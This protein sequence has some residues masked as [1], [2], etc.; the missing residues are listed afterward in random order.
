MSSATQDGSNGFVR[1]GRVNKTDK[2]RRSWSTQEE[3]VLLAALKELVV[4]GWKSDNGFR[5]GYLTK[6]EE[7]MK[8]VFP[9][10]DLKGM[11]HINS[12][13]TTWKKQYYSLTQI[14]GNT[15]VGFNVNGMHMVDCND[16]QW[17]QIIKVSRC[18]YCNIKFRLYKSVPI[19]LRDIAKILETHVTI[20]EKL[21]AFLDVSESKISIKLCVECLHGE[22]ESG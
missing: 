18:S 20:S 1:G 5:P 14:L 16:E 4:Q 3:A 8:K 22:D 12:K 11:P 9:T 6:L 2:T 17:E 15:G 7:A 10:T 13:T 21:N 19:G